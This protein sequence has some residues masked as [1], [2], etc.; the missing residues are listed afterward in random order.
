MK[1][2]LPESQDWVKELYQITFDMSAM[3]SKIYAHSTY[4]GLG[5]QDGHS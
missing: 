5:Q 3:Q 2:R 1:F 4:F